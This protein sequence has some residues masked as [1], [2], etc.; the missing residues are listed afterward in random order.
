[1][2][3]TSKGQ[4]LDVRVLQEM[5]FSAVDVYSAIMWIINDL[6]ELKEYLMALVTQD[7]TN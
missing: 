3:H 1:M 5:L 7:V 6:L 2:S 4:R